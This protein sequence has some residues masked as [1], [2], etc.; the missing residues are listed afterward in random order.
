MDCFATECRAS[1]VFIKSKSRR[2]GLRVAEL[3]DAVD[4]GRQTC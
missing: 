3:Y 1:I 2:F 4:E